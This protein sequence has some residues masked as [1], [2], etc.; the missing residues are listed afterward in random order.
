MTP[1]SPAAEP[2]P[3]EAAA[4]LLNGS[5]PV[6][7]G[8]VRDGPQQKDGITVLKYVDGDLCPDQIRKKSTTIRFTCSENQVVS[9][10]VSSALGRGAGASKGGGRGDGVCLLWRCESQGS[11]G[12]RG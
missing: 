5:K 12:R 2:C 4:C 10:S 6:N 7:L 1:V 3:P 11:G 8:R 9:D